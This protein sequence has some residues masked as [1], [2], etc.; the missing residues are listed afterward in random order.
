MFETK[1]WH[2][3]VHESA[4][5]IFCLEAG[6]AVAE[7]RLAPRGAVL[8]DRRPDDRLNCWL[9]AHAGHEAELQ[10]CGDTWGPSDSD[11]LFGE[12]PIWKNE[13]V[14]W[15]TLLSNRVGDLSPLILHLALDLNEVSRDVWRKHQLAELVH[16]D[17]A[18][19]QYRPLY[20]KPAVSS[21]SSRM[22][23]DRDNLSAS[24]A[25]I[26]DHFRHGP[27]VKTVRTSGSL[28]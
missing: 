2:T 10:I 19:R 21:H 13:R 24:I 1:R 22:S 16:A 14:T 18:Y 23:R 20:D 9:L 6:V 15:P 11:L 25:G 12:S 5:A 7:L 8:P 4:H 26:I 3:I 17:D 28:I 27:N